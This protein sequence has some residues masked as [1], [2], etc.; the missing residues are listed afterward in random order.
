MA[1]DPTGG[2]TPGRSSGRGLVGD[3]ALI[4]GASALSRVSGLVR[5][6]VAASVLGSTVLGDL[7][8]AVNVLPL[9]LYDVMAG[10]GFTSVL[11]PPLVRALD[12]DRSGRAARRLTANTLGVVVVATATIA[13]IAVVGRRWIA[14]ALTAGVGGELASD[15]AAVAGLLLALILPQLVLYAAIGV[16]VSVQ[17][18]HRRFLLP[19][20]APIVENVGLVA[21][22]VT[23]WA[24]YGGGWEVDAVPPGLVVMLALGSGLSVLAHALVQFAG[25]WRASGGVSVGLEWRHP[26]LRRLARPMRDSFGWSGVI[27]GRQFALIVAA[28]FAGAGGV[29]A[30][31]IATLVYFVPLAL[32]GRPVASAALPRL[33]RSRPAPST[34]DSGYVNALRLAA[35]IAVPAGVGLVVLSGPLADAIAQGRFDRPESTRM[36]ALALAGL[37]I[38]AAGDALFEVARQTTMAQG[39]R[40]GLGRSTLVRA[41]VAA[42]GIPIAIVVFDGPLVLLGLGLVVSLGDVAAFALTHAAL[43]ARLSWV[44]DGERHWPRIAAASILAVVPVALVASVL[45]TAPDEVRAVMIAAAV[46]TLYGLAAVAVTDRGRMIRSLQVMLRSGELA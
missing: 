6:V 19:S 8:V 30:F 13:A 14:A 1:V 23:A 2:R 38:G 46:I 29:Q 25:A 11:V 22:I 4:A 34:L 15:A 43:R 31:E 45:P 44:D 17:Q 42:T 24:V 18:A 10:S 32:V 3:S 12:D 40:V 5:I 37:G 27:A 16:F 41:I 39:D 9:I 33:S 28:G 20:A 7:F 36:L 35:W 21:T 26:A